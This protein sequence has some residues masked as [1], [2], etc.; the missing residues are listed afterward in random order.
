MA[1]GLPAEAEP[2]LR[3][4]VDLCE[5]VAEYAFRLGY[6]LWLLGGEAQVASLHPFLKAAKLQPTHSK[7]GNVS[8]N[9]FSLS[10]SVLHFSCIYNPVFVSV[11]S[12]SP[13]PIIN[14]T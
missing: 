6:A 9:M 7:V 12:N 3:Q 4:A 8:T 1:K 14:N 11:L 5:S 10:F 13:T 2:P